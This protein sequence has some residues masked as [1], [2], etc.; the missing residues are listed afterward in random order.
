MF[1]L[2]VSDTL[3]FAHLLAVAVGFGVAVETEAFMIRRRRTVI[4]PGMLSGL[5][6]R[7]R[8]ILWALGAMWVTGLALVALRTGFQLSAFTPKLWAKITVVTI[9]SVNAF[10]VAEVA[11]PIIAEHKGRPIAALSGP[12]Q[13][14]LFSVAGIS[15]ASW[16]VALA[17]GSSA[18]LKVSPADFFQTALPVAYVAGIVGANVIGRKLYEKPRSA[19]RRASASAASAKRVPTATRAPK[20]APRPAP[21]DR[22][23]APSPP[24]QAAVRKVRQPAATAVEVRASDLAIAFPPKPKRRPRLQPAPEANPLSGI[25]RQRLA[26]ATTDFRSGS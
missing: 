19:A 23:P 26:D 11:L 15:A 1:E 17:L 4:S 21:E 9:L 20:A 24:P 16:F 13:S 22:A 10:F 18:I 3:R 6:H 7:H 12:A 8:V 14:A 5:D 25:A 2:L